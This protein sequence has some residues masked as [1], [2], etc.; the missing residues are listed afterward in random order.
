M[1]DFRNSDFIGLGLPIWDF[2]SFPGDYEFEI[3]ALGLLNNA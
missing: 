2:K 3:T 1:L